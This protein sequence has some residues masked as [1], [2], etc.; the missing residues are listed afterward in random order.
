MKPA[1]I[2]R[3]T[4]EALTEAHKETSQ[5]KHIEMELDDDTTRTE[6]SPQPE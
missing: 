1:V 6:D 3:K 5:P 4:I 2:A